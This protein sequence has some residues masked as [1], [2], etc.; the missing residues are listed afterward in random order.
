MPNSKAKILVDCVIALCGCVKI[1]ITSV[2]LSFFLF[3][4]KDALHLIPKSGL[5]FILIAYFVDHFLNF[6]T[7]FYSQGKI[8]T[9]H[10]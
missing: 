10:S 3:H 4:I 6:L 1:F 2:K 7:G 9:E 8:I 5:I